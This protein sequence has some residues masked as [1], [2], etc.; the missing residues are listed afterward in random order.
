MGDKATKTSTLNPQCPHSDGKALPVCW[1]CAEEGHVNNLQTE[2]AC[3]SPSWSKFKEFQRSFRFR[4][5]SP[6]MI[7]TSPTN[8]QSS[9]PEVHPPEEGLE[10]GTP[11]IRRSQPGLIVL[12]GPRIVSPEDKLR[13]PNHKSWHSESSQKDR[14]ESEPATNIMGLRRR[15]FQVFVAIALLAIAGVII[16]VAVSVTQRK[17]LHSTSFAISNNGQVSS[18]PFSRPSI[19]KTASLYVTSDS[20]A[21]VTM[22]KTEIPPDSSSP[23]RAESTLAVVEKPSS[24]TITTRRDGGG[25][26]E[27]TAVAFISTASIVTEPVSPTDPIASQPTATSITT[28]DAL[29]LTKTSSSSAP[30]SSSSSRNCLGDDGSTYTDP[31]T[32][33]KFKIEC[34]VAHQGRDIENLEAET[35]EDCVSLC[36]KNDQCK[37][38]IWYNVGP[39]GTDL[40]YCWLKSQMADDL[41][42]TPDAQSV[43]RL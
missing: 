37:G 41:R 35:M 29:P 15:T 12:T 33:D 43:V 19:T 24:V 22:L 31:N 9:A 40:N 16:G 14:L 28:S 5:G 17:G 8:V 2:G 30:S 1:D 38:A 10:V 25:N 4:G 36:A 6:S 32:G 18:S 21:F 27:P 23:P 7:N 42:D 3:V 34:A 13:R 20:S 11:E 26:T 39:Q